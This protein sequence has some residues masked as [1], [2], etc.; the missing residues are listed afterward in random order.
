M[1]ARLEYADVK[2]GRV[3]P[4]F[5]VSTFLP[6]LVGCL[7]VAVM[8]WMLPAA[9]AILAVAL[10]LAGTLVPWLTGY[11]AGRKESRFAGARG[12]LATAVVDLTE[13]AAELVA[14]GAAGVPMGMI[15]VPSI[16]GVSHSPNELTA[17]NDCTR[18]ADAL[19]ETILQ[20]DK[21]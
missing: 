15:F 4:A 21:A 12:D 16:G 2:E 17:W 8:W 1:I 9:G 18:G 20:I 6:L 14:F 3:S 10:V 7:T 13:G 11:L 5:V 19:L